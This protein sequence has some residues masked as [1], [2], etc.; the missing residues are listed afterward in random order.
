MPSQLRLTLICAACV[1]TLGAPATALAQAGS[2]AGTAGQQTQQQPSDA[3]GKAVQPPAPP[4]QRGV[5][6]GC[7]YRDGKLELIV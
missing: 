5:P 2:A 6:S 7:P 1:A 3:N 4:Q